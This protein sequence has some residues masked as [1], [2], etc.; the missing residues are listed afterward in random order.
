METVDIMNYHIEEGTIVHANVWELHNDK[1]VWGSDPSTF[2]PERYLLYQTNTYA[3][4]WNVGTYVSFFKCLCVCN[5][6][7]S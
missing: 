4:I 1:S 5:Y 3:R 6:L 7:V 2:D